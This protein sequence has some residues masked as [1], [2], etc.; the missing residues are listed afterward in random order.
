G[1]TAAGAAG[2]RAGQGE[3][4]AYRAAANRSTGDGATRSDR[5][6]RGREQRRGAAE[7]CEP[8]LS[9]RGPARGPERLGGGRFHGYAGG[10]HLGRARGRCAA[11]TR[12]RSFRDGGGEPLPLQAGDARR[13][14]GG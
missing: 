11:A 3:T 4:A 7:G 14:R 1:R 2:R 13:Q 8:E 6:R 9:H 10:P 5:G 12:V